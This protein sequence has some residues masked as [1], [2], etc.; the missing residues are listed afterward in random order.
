MSTHLNDLVQGIPLTNSIN[1]QFVN[2][3]YLWLD[4]GYVT[5]PPGVY[6]NGDFS[7]SVW[8]KAVNLANWQR[9]FDFGNGPASD[10]VLMITTTNE[11]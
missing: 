8:I 5:A 3:S 4:S 6:F 9:V 11:G 2:N 1:A 10:N 7:V